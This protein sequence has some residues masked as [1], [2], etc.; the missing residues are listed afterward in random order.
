MRE[1]KFKFSGA[2]LMILTVAAAVSALINF[3]QQTRFKLPDDGV[4]WVDRNGSVKAFHVTH[5]S[6]A[7]RVGIRRGDILL[8]IAGSPIENAI[9]VSQVLVS[10]GAWN[11]ATYVLRRDGV[12]FEAPLIVGTAL[13]NYAAIYWQYLVGLV[14]LGVGL[15]VFFRRGNAPRSLHFYTLCLASF[16]LST[17]HFT[18]KLNSFDK[19][20]YYGNVLAG[21]FAP[22][23][24]LHF[25]L[26]F[27]E[28]RGWFRRR[29][30]MFLVYVPATLVTAVLLGVSS[31]VLRV[32]L[33]AIELNWLLDRIWVLFLAATYL[34]GGWVLHRTYHRVEDP[35]VRQ[36]I[37]WLRNGAILGAAPFALVYAIPYGLL[38]AIPST[39]MDAAVLSFVLIPITWAYAIVRYRLMD[40]DIIFQQGYVYTL[41]TICVLAVF[42]GLIF[43]VGGLEDL[44]PTASGVLILIAAFVF[45]PIRK[46]IQELLDRYVFYKDKYDYRL[47]LIEFA[48]ELSSETDLDALLRSVADRLRRTLSIER[49]AFFLSDEDGRFRLRDPEAGRYDRRH[50]DLSFLPAEPDRPYLFFEQTKHLLDVV[51]KNWPVAVRNTI[52]DLDLTYY[53]PCLVR[54]RTIAYLG[55]SRTE[56]GDFLTSEDLELLVTVSGYVAIAI[57]NARLYRSLALKMQEYERLKE[58]SENIV[59]SINVGILAADLDDRVESWN[60]RMEQLTGVARDAAVGRGLS[61]LLPADLV[62]QFGSARGE[63]GIHHIYRFTLRPKAAA[64]V[65]EMPV[66][67]SNG[68]STAAG[69]AA[70][71]EL[72]AQPETILNIAVAPLVS[73]DL[74]QIGRLII[75]DDVTERDEL[76]RRLVQADKLSSVGLLAAGVAHEVNTPLAVIST[77]AQML[78]KQV[79]GDDQKSRLLEKIAKQTFRA[80]EIVNSLLNFSRTSP[81]SFDELNLNRIIH[82]S[83]ALIQ[84]QMEKAGIRV[85]L[86][87]E[88]QLPC[89][90]GN[91]GKLQQVFLNLFLNARDAMGTGGTLTV[92]TYRKAEAVGVDVADTGHGIQPENLNRIFDPFFTTK[93]ARKGTGL[94]LSVTYGIVR[95]HSGVIEVESQPG[96]GTRFHLEFPAARKAV[97]A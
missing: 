61:E 65:I 91:S 39:Y 68:R 36:Q 76:E 19:A 97:H 8:K 14:Y 75:F 43:W 85:Q 53:L 17:F 22:T 27:P 2:L 41:A 60:S 37:K 30:R 89:I 44:G 23:I 80:S 38:G 56:G 84:H 12:E 31:G 93:A 25:C 77:Y 4:T 24:F 96:E 34:F 26:A 35:I 95:E 7:D 92:R 21:L 72:E 81:T 86:D 55:V 78:A 82:E 11:K 74:E 64:N 67:G 16:V 94:G 70:Q 57:E 48:R 51:S 69:A 5:D 73:K 62:A 20:M 66:G 46:W 33:D 83:L 88:E 6:P 32:A 42:Y 54:G 50:Y 58:Y 13:R 9:E 63:N 18:G 40:V 29:A 3:Q 52:S 10:I 15:F 71:P 28:K 90:K 87:L 45:Q 79:S 1:L 49:V 47:T 59:E